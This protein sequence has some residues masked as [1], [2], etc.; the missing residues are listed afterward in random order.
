MKLH[1]LLDPLAK[2]KVNTVETDD[3]I[4]VEEPDIRTYGQR[5]HDALEDVC[6]RMLRSDT[7]FRMP[8]APRPR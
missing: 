5:M 3:G 1:T 8:V 2:S 6:D 7:L 4:R